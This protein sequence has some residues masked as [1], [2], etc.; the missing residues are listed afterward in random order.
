MLF[1]STKALNEWDSRYSGGVD[2]RQKLDVQPGAVLANELK[3]NACKLAKW[4]VQALLVGSDIIKFG[5]ITR[6]KVKDSS[7]HVILGSQQF[8]PLE[9]ANQINLSMD[10]AWGIVRCIIDLVMQ[11]KDGK[12]LIVK[13]P[14]KPVLRLYDIPDSTFES[15]EDSD[16]DDDVEDDVLEV[17][18]KA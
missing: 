12:Y 13:D 10:N 18:L 11:Q 3:H 8:K 16:E 7:R 15:D 1:L 2:W 4:T 17:S 14:N 6:F 5:Y 9:F